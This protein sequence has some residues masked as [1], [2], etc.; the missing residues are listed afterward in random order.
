M[1]TLENIQGGSLV[2]DPTAASRG[3]ATGFNLRSAYRQRGIEDEQREAQAQRQARI[4]SLTPEALKGGQD[5]M[6]SLVSLDPKLANTIAGIMQDRNEQ[7]SDK[8]VTLNDRIGATSA[9]ALSAAPNV[10]RQMYLVEAQKFTEEGNEGAAQEAL[11]MAQWAV[12]DP[13][14]FAAEANKDLAMS[15]NVKTLMDLAGIGKGA[16]LKV[17]QVQTSQILPGGGVIKVM[18]GGSVVVED[19]Q[20]N[21]LTGQE[22]AD[23]IRE[24][25]QRGVELQA[26]R[27]GART[28]A[29]KSEQ[30]TQGIIDRGVSAAESTAGLRRGIELLDTIKTGGYSAIDMR[31]RAALGIEGA[32]EGELANSLGTA[33]LS[34]LK[35]T[36]G[37]AFTEGEGARLERLSASMGKSPEANKR[38]LNQALKIAESASRRA[39]KAAKA[40][41]DEETVQDIEGLLK[42]TLTPEPEISDEDLANKYL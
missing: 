17:D 42:F 18:K 5:A 31:T 37:S 20:G 25:E 29:T 24:A 36:F 39:I 16:E 30:R 3:F 10:Q 33:V 41:G 22:R 26:G 7:A 21:V 11:Q 38:I 27:A 40:R 13:E 32:D 15:G 12:T 8:L 23:S 2:A 28:E 1:P 9:A 34:Q 19:A 6:N 4:Q 14:R 35:A